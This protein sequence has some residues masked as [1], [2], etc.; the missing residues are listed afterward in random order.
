ME[1][2]G[3]VV[4]CLCAVVFITLFEKHKEYAIFLSIIV[5]ITIFFVFM[6][7]FKIIL[8]IIK[9][10]NGYMQIDDAYLR[11]LLQIMGIAFITEFGAGICKDSG[12]K[13]IASNIE[14]AGK[15]MI[16]VVAAPILMAILNLIS[17]IL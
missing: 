9:K 2:V 3:I 8:E 6:D 12:Q 14:L 11:V 4:L 13:A 7:Q 17:E 1:I 16:L 10:L 5:A 15:I